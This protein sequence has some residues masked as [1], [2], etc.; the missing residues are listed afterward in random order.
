MFIELSKKFLRRSM[1]F[2]RK[3]MS[4]VTGRFRSHR[5]ITP[6]GLNGVDALRGR[7]EEASRRV[8]QSERVVDGW[9]D[10]IDRKQ[11]EG[12]DVFAARSLLETFQA[13]LE[14]AIS[15]KTEAQEALAQRL[16]DLFKGANGRASKT[17]HELDEWLT[18]PEGRAAT[19]FEPTPLPRWRE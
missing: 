15:D 14:A 2:E 12:D 3:I 17:N 9:R 13:S 10:L 7:L 4:R 18:S 5:A 6:H 1:E 11:V 19:A 16:R 8:G